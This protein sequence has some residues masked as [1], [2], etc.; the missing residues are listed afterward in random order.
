[1]A[2]TPPSPFPFTPKRVYLGA[3]IPM[4]VIRRYARA[5]PEE[6]HPDKIILF[7]SYA[8]GTPQEDSSASKRQAVA[9]F[10]WAGRV[11]KPAR[12]LLGI[13]ERPRSK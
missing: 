2:R 13:R 12:A 11:C 8:Y 5:I 10:R 9:A 7:G 1:M 4:R 3:D 6:F